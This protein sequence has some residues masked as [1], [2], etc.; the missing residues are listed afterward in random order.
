M[1]WYTYV[2]LSSL[3]LFTASACAPTYYNPIVVRPA[4]CSRQMQFAESPDLGYI[5]AFADKMEKPVFLDFY[6]PWIPT[7]KRIDENVFT[8]GAVAAYFNQNFVNY[9]VNAGGATPGPELTDRYGVTTFPTFI[10]VDGKGKIMLRHE[11]Y[12]TADQLL[13]MGQFLHHAGDEDVLS[14]GTK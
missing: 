8:Q 2:I 7:C 3:F 4:S 1:K 6:A 12:V 13:E 11:G 14:L 9:K 10:F 5:L